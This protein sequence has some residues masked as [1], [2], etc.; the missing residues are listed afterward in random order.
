MTD[1]LSKHLKN[2]LQEQNLIAYVWHEETDDM[3]WG[4]D[5]AAFANIRSNV[6]PNLNQTTSP[7]K[8][9]AFNGYLNP[10][11]V[12]ERMQ[13]LHAILKGVN[14]PYKSRHLATSIA[15]VFQNR[16][17]T[18]FCYYHAFFSD[19]RKIR[20]NRRHHFSPLCA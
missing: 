19:C 3:Q 15:A 11:H 12:P 13:M 9:R 1:L 8:G 10:A 18:A 5:F 7:M 6:S 16:L 14:S 4:D 20:C 2:L 17:E